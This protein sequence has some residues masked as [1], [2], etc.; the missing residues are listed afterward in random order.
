MRPS[1]ELVEMNFPLLRTEETEGSP[2]R[3]SGLK[4]PSM[5]SSMEGPESFFLTKMCWKNLFEPPKVSRYLRDAPPRAESWSAIMRL[6]DCH[7]RRASE[8]SAIAESEKPSAF[9]ASLIFWESSISSVGS[10]SLTARRLEIGEPISIPC[11]LR[12]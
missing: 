5:R 9:R 8:S 2:V 6:T 4:A 12:T 7:S 1:T 11:F 3:V 10:K